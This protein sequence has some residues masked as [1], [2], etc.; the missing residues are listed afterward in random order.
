MKKWMGIAAIVLTA[1]VLGM[2][3]ASAA[4]DASGDATIS[5]L[6]DSGIQVSDTTATTTYDLQEGLQQTVTDTTG[7]E[8]DHSYI[9]VDV[10]GTPIL[11]LDPPRPMF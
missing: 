3:M 5:V 2:G 6:P 10:A 8:V 4:Y 9:W 7:L 11:A 1:Q